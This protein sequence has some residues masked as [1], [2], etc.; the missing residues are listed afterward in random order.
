MNKT[1][2]AAII[3]DKTKLPI[4][5]MFNPVE[6][7]KELFLFQ[8]LQDIGI[9]VGISAFSHN[10]K[11]IDSMMSESPDWLN[12]K[13]EGEENQI[14]YLNQLVNIKILQ[15]IYLNWIDIKKPIGTFFS[16]SEN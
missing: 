12:K 8:F 11:L 9:S 7:E 4:L 14:I 16:I 15:G 10:K 1:E 3:L 2:N 6:T 5:E 13:I